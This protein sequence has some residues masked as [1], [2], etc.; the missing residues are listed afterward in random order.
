LARAGEALSLR[1]NM[2]STRQ[3]FFEIKGLPAFGNQYII[4]A[5]ES[6]DR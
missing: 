4:H 5:I 1:R 3:I 2:Q 6:T